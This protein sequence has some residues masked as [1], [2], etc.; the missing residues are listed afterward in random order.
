[1]VRERKLE[2]DVNQINGQEERD[3]EETKKSKNTAG[4][5]VSRET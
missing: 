4:A 1:M 5:T 2:I 3:G